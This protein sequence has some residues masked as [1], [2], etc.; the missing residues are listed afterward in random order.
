VPHA[1]ITEADAEGYVL[2][3]RQELA[4]QPVAYLPLAQREAG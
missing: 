4:R 3:V 2:T 1:F